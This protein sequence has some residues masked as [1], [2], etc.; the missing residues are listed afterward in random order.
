[1]KQYSPEFSFEYFSSKVISLLKMILFAEDVQEL[2]QYT[3]NLSGELYPDVVDA[4]FAGA[5]A[6]KKFQIV[7][8]YAELDVDAYVEV[9]HDKEWRIKRKVEK[10]RM[11][12]RRNVKVPIDY[13]FSIKKIQCKNCAGSFDA[14][15]FKTCPNCGTKYDIGDDDWVVT[16]IEKR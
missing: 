12:L 13:H 5:I 10:Y 16:S 2:A 9:M 15:K 4:T 8:D 14:T 6:L 3:G 7:G 11:H 1:M